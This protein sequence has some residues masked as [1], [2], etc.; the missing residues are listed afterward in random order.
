MR[1]HFEWCFNKFS[2]FNIDETTSSNTTNFPETRSNELRPFQ[3]KNR[4][5]ALYF[6]TIV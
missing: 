1:K 3:D 4:F 2:Q 6:Q 5:I